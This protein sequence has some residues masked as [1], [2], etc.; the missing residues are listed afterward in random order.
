VKQP[1]GE[2][3]DS[4]VETG[5]PNIYD[6]QLL[7]NA[8]GPV[9][10]KQEQLEGG[11]ADTNG[12]AGVR[13]EPFVA[14][15]PEE[16]PRTTPAPRKRTSSARLDEEASDATGRKSKALPSELADPQ[17]AT[18]IM[19]QNIPNLI[20][21]AE[22]CRQLR[23]KGFEG[24]YDYLYLPMN[25]Q[26]QQ[27]YG[28]G[29]VN[30]RTAEASSKFVK[31]FHGLHASVCLPGYSNSKVCHVSHAKVQGRDENLERFSC[32]EVVNQLAAV[33]DWQPLFFDDAGQAMG[34][35]FH[36]ARSYEVDNSLL[37]ADNQKGVAY[38]SSKRLEDKWTASLETAAGDILEASAKWGS[39]VTGVDEGDGWVRVGSRY[40]PKFVHGHMVLKVPPIDGVTEMNPE[41]PAFVPRDSTAAD[42]P[43]FW[44]LMML[45]P[46]MRRKET[47]TD[48]PELTLDAQDKEQKVRQQVEYYL[49]EE[50]LRTDS[51]L[52]GLMDVDG[53]VSLEDVVAF[54]RMKGFGVDAAAV[55]KALACS[56]SL[57]V[58][59]DGV[60]HP[61]RVRRRSSS[62]G[63]ADLC[64][65]SAASPTEAATEEQKEDGDSEEKTT[66]NE[67]APP[68]SLSATLQAITSATAQKAY[69][70]AEL[71]SATFEAFSSA[72]R[73]ETRRGPLKAAAP[74]LRP[75]PLQQVIQPRPL[76][77][78]PQ[79][80]QK[81]QLSSTGQLNSSRSSFPF[82]AAPGAVRNS[83]MGTLR[84]LSPVRALS[85][86]PVRGPSPS[87][88]LSPRRLVSSASAVKPTQVPVRC[89]SPPSFQTQV[90]TA[91]QE[92]RPVTSSFPL[93]SAAVQQGRPARLSSPPVL[94]TP[95]LPERQVGTTRLPAK[96]SASMPFGIARSTTGGRQSPS[97]VSA[98]RPM[99]PSLPA[100]AVAPNSPRLS[101]PSSAWR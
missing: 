83:S 97:L 47:D 8:R 56:S 41:A 78:Q 98:T 3:G 58:S 21:R 12:L 82:S 26:N 25:P 86:S 40:L 27:N 4:A 101:L 6:R 70:G 22:F 5:G 93:T 63:A 19:L 9:L 50:N 18:T 7:L 13:L 16:V 84:C 90:P 29:F 32:S 20:D 44:N 72:S 37:K 95:R 36:K 11:D 64:A 94:S 48:V 71:F 30:L 68:D 96:V 79:L 59:P 24:L 77:Q 65:S 80:L 87:P 99:R 91:K 35:G 92:L 33:P 51:F 73:P 10:G 100:G 89:L 14:A 85:P 54:P 28:Y 43:M 76:Q 15:P 46:S 75:Q 74:Q 39:T 88:F 69:R 45:S 34:H 62:S 57:E 81:L 61:L 52:Q 55:A 38:R 17:G 23:E 66:A 2:V 1:P 31:A 42:A 49:S 60:A 53:W 67:A